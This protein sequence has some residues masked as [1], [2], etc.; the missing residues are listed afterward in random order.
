VNCRLCH[1][2]ARLLT[3]K[4]ESGGCNVAQVSLAHVPGGRRDRD[5]ALLVPLA[6]DSYLHVGKVEVVDFKAEKL[7]E[8][9][10]AVYKQVEHGCIAWRQ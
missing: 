3:G 7:I 9:Q 5:G 4:Q 6:D 8:P 1:L 10:A 2:A